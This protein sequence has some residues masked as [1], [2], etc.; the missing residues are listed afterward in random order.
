MVSATHT[1]IEITEKINALAN[2]HRSGKN[3]LYKEL[4]NSIRIVKYGVIIGIEYIGNK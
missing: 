3:V 2:K 4:Y 1:L